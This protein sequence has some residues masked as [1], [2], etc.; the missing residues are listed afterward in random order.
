MLPWEEISE[1]LKESNRQQADHIP[2]KLRRIGCGF[3]PVTG[4][5][6][7]RIAFS[8]AEVEILGEIEHERWVAEKRLAGYTLGPRDHDKKT[9]PYLVDWQDLSEEVKEWDR[10]PV[11]EIPVFMAAASFEIYRLD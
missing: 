8:D 7:V 4:R 9:S 5:E 3:I 10:Q 1:S 2:A 6:P 11:R